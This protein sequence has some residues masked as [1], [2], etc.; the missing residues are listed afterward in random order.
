MQLQTKECWKMQNQRYRFDGHQHR[1]DI[2]ATKHRWT[3]KVHLERQ[4]DD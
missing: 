3:V 4:A 1:S 2:K